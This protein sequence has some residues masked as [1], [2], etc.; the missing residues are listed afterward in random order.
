MKEVVKMRK[1]LLFLCIFFMMAF[2]SCSKSES[3]LTLND[4]KK[5]GELSTLNVYCYNVAKDKEK[6]G[7]FLQKERDIWIEYEGSVKYG[8]DFDKIKT[9]ISGNVV[10]ITLPEPKVTFADVNEGTVQCYISN[11]GWLIKNEVSFETQSKMLTKAQSDMKEKS[12]SN[13]KYLNLA[14]ER[15]KPI[16][17]NYVDKFGELAGVEYEIKWK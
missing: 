16:I 2:C 13:E 1:V 7:S 6:A 15:A 9:E 10:K 4:M 17:E 3:A 12:E 5:I 11:D 8:I 14:I